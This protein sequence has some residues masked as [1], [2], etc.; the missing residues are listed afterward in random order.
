[1]SKGLRRI[2]EVNV[3]GKR[4]PIIFSPGLTEKEN[5]LAF[6]DDTKKSIT[7]DDKILDSELVS[8][9]IHEIGHALFFRGGVSQTSILPDVLEMI[10]EQFALVIDENFELKKKPRKRQKVQ[11]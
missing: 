5:I 3:L 8:T 4:I 9:L 2:K 10:V 7:I 11:K 6:Y 1:M